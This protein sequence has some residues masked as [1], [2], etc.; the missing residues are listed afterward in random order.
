MRRD[1]IST[2]IGHLSS[3]H[4]NYENWEDNGKLDKP[5]TLQTHLRKFPTFYK[6]NMSDSSDIDNDNIRIKLFVD[7]DWK[8][9]SYFGKEIQEMVSPFCNYGRNQTTY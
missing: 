3:Y 1:I 4:S 5:P 9:V 8:F 2:A 6:G 7:N